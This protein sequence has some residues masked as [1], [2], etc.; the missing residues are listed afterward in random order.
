MA[1]QA[2]MIERRLLLG[3]VAALVAACSPEANSANQ[4]P[5]P[6]GFPA[7][8][9]VS[10]QSFERFLEGMPAAPGFRKQR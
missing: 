9:P 7:Y 5:A 3:G 2:T 1:P 4:T 8:Q 10:G 6:N